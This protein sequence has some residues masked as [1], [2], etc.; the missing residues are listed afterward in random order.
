MTRLS[1]RTLDAEVRVTSPSPARKA[2]SIVLERKKN[3]QTF[4]SKIQK[5]TRRH[6]TEKLEKETTKNFILRFIFVR[7]GRQKC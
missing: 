1:V 7:A 2:A 4:F 5:M 6:F 3:E